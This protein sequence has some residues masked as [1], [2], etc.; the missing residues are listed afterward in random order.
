MENLSKREAGK[1]SLA[2]PLGRREKWEFGGR[3]NRI[4]YNWIFK[5]PYGLIF[6]PYF[7]LIFYSNQCI[8]NYHSHNNHRYKSQ[9]EHC[10]DFLL[11]QRL[12]LNI[13]IIS[14]LILLQEAGVFR[15]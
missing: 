9:L 10:C 15:E 3:V 14:F 1:Y 4:Y 8:S 5:N 6:D 12:V 11:L 7:P 2:G 13:T